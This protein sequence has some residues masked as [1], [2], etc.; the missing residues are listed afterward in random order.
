[1]SDRSVAL[2]HFLPLEWYPPVMNLL[3]FMEK[4]EERRR[5][6][7]YT[8]Q[9]QGTPF[10]VDTP[11]IKIDRLTP[12]DKSMGSLA[13][14]K[15]YLLFYL[16]CFLSLVKQRPSAVLYYETISSFP[17]W[18]YKRTVGRR[19]RLLIHYHEYTSPDEYVSGMR[20][21]RYFHKKEQGL[22]PLAAWI[23]QTNGDR[24]AKFL[25]DEQLPPA[26]PVFSLP[27]YPPRHWSRKPAPV[28][29]RPLRIVYVGA[30]S[31]DT[32]YLREFA[33]WVLNRQGRVVWHLYSGNYTPEAAD[34][35]RNLPAEIIKLFPSVNYE[36]LPEVLAGY[37]VGVILYKGHIPNYV[38]N[39]PNKL[40]EYFACGLDVWFPQVMKGC[41][42]YV[43]RGTYPKIVSL[44]FDNLGVLDP[45][46][47]VD[48]T[49]CGYQQ[50]EFAYE[51]VLPQLT[52][53]LFQ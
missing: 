25:E 12:Y 20:L 50:P 48:R 8:T 3:R 38:F 21:N 7:V 39:A 34:L 37:D 45:D 26:T 32:L 9:G 42:A 28:T 18:L 36:N 1:M 53:C 22:Y 51:L 15:T 16:R 43:T 33:E 40:F 13:R 10:S 2:V 19:T 11:G 52:D 14:Y 44:D 30:L 27:N 46:K 49:D 4:E 17:V 24:V 5:V 31:P 6:I 47:A 41:L 23:S 35:L 29:G